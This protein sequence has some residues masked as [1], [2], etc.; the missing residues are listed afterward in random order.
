MTWMLCPWV[1]EVKWSCMREATRGS[2]CWQTS[3]ITDPTAPRLK[4]ARATK[5]RRLPSTARHRSSPPGPSTSTARMGGQRGNSPVCKTWSMTVSRATCGRPSGVAMT[6][7]TVLWPNRTAR[8]FIGTAADLCEQRERRAPP[9]PPDWVFTG[10][11]MDLLCGVGFGSES[12]DSHL[13]RGG[14]GRQDAHGHGGGGGG[15]AAG[16]GGGA[17]GGAAGGI[18][19][20][21]RDGGGTAGGAGR[22]ACGVGFGSQSESRSMSARAMP[23]TLQAC[24]RP[25]TTS[26]C[27][28]SSTAGSMKPPRMT[29]T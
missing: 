24:R 1:E 8:G 25:A 16:G 18:V 9:A 20:G 13:G 19:C 5:R 29:S 6:A 4:A 10:G 21:S 23:H 22:I 11:V 26:P 15:G 17:A 7:V 12:K 28:S 2:S 3:T 14:G 27:S